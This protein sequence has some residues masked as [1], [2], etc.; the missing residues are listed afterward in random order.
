MRTK[1]EHGVALITVLL[2]LF[3]VSALVVGMSWMV[4]SD[5]RL[6]GN[7]QNREIAFYGAEAGMEK[8]TSDMGNIFAVTGAITAANLVTITAAATGY[9]R[10]Y[11]YQRLGRFDLSRSA[12]RTPPSFVPPRQPERHHS[13]SQPVSGMNGLITPFTLSVASQSNAGRR[14]QTPAQRSTRRDSGFPVRHFF[15]YGLGVLQR[16]SIRFWR[17]RSHQRQPLAGCRFRPAIH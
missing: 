10:R 9:S 8:M 2:I 16:S 5:Q 7:N 11:V 13:A 15:Q 1:R 17:P 3:L 14:G 6:G 12:A 4:M